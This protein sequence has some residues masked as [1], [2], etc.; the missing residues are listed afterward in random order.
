MSW[1]FKRALTSAFIAAAVAAPVAGMAATPGV[2]DAR[3]NPC[4][5]VSAPFAAHKSSYRASHYVCDG[6]TYSVF[7]AR[8]TRDGFSPVTRASQGA[9]ASTARTGPS[10]R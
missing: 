4:R 3:R 6:I 1:S 2:R 5:L 9:S 8:L 7:D 10:A